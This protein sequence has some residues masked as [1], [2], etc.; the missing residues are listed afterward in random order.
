MDAPAPILC[1]KDATSLLFAKIWS[2]YIVSII[3]EALCVIVVLEL[4][5]DSTFGLPFAD[6]GNCIL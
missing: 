1:E 4:A 2:R 5:A 3:E 6:P